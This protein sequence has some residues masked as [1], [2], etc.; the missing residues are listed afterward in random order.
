[1]VSEELLALLVCPMG[2]APLR[3]RAK[4]GLHPV[5]ARGSRSR[6]TSPNMLIEEAE[7]PP[8]CDSLAD[9]DCVKIGGDRPSRDLAMSVGRSSWHPDSRKSARQDRSMALLASD[10]G[11][12][13]TARQSR[14]RDTPGDAPRDRP[15]HSLEL[16]RTRI[17]GW[18][19]HRAG[20]G[21]RSGQAATT[22][23]GIPAPEVPDLRRAASS[24]EPAGPLDQ[25]ATV[26]A[27]E[28][29]ARAIGR[30]CG[31]DSAQAGSPA[32]S[33]GQSSGH[34]IR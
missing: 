18:R 14:R 24:S 1:M 23:R 32:G 30:A 21:P 19:L 11:R 2:K 26:V 7:L 5:R 3:A 29:V 25:K 34:L 20:R 10:D 27:P 4:P 12:R 9:L 16:G 6:T 33:T 28:S 17:P 15:R 22:S 31:T 8:G 13:R